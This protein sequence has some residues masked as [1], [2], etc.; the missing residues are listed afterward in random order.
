MK[1]QEIAEKSTGEII[2]DW[3]ASMEEHGIHV[4]LGNGPKFNSD[5]NLDV[6]YVSLSAR[7][8]PVLL[9]SYFPFKLNVGVIVIDGLD[10][11]QTKFE[12]MSEYTDSETVKL[13]HCK[14]PQE[15]T[16][17]WLSVLLPA[18]V[19]IH[20]SMNNIPNLKHDVWDGTLI[21][22]INLYQGHHKIYTLEYTD[23]DEFIFRD[24]ATTRK[25]FNDIFDLQ[26][27]LVSYNDERLLPLVS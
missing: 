11:T 2:A 12:F 26:E 20:T 8:N 7:N 22:S 13:I 1:L 15:I 18:D 5:G 10:L 16:G 23:D 17:D 3:I 9:D 19:E 14:W 25:V 21:F 24:Y 6:N 4:A 27:F